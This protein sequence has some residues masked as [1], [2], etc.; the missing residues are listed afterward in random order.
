[1]HI[2]HV[3]DLRFINDSNKAQEFADHKY[4]Y[5]STHPAYK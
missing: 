4:I 3:I 2:T 1:M 5:Y